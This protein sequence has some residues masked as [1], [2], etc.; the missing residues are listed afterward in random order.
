MPGTDSHRPDGAGPLAHYLPLPVAEQ[1]LSR[2]TAILAV[3][4]G[5]RVET[6]EDTGRIYS[7]IGSPR[8]RGEPE[9]VELASGFA[10]NAGTAG[11]AGIGVSHH[12]DHDI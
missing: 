9:L 6:G 4:C 5:G 7:P 12:A 10:E 3:M 11:D 8:Q 2:G 1:L